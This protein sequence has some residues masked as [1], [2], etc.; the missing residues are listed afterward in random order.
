[1]VYIKTHLGIK[2]ITCVICEDTFT[3]EGPR[4][5][6]CTK[7]C[8][9][10]RAR[11]ASKKWYE[12]HREQVLGERCEKSRKFRETQTLQSI[13]NGTRNRAKDKG[14]DFDINLDDLGA[15]SVCPVFGEPFVRKTRMGMSIDRI[16]PTKG[17][18][19]GNV[20]VISKLANVMKND[21]SVDELRLFANWI[22]RNYPD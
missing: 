6:T 17:Y 14:I 7:S 22:K 15:P 18:I 19:K 3:Q 10:E 8:A 13:F 16:D 5:N 12:E 21:A 11:R 1:M 4:Q 20:Q 2:E 9:R